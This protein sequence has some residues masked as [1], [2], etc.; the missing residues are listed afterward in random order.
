[1]VPQGE[2]K[3]EPVVGIGKNIMNSTRYIYYY[4]EKGIRRRNWE[5]VG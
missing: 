2:R 3:G 5:A 4:C 1:M